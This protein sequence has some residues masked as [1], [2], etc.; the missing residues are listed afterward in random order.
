[1]PITD[2]RLWIERIAY[3]PFCICIPERH[4][5]AS[6]ARLAM[7]ELAGETLVWIPRSLHWQFYDQVASYLRPLGFDSRRFL[8]ASTITQAFDFAALGIGVALIPQ[9][10]SHFQRVGVLVKPLT[11]ELMRIETSL[12]VRRDQMHSQVKDFIAT[13]LSAISKMKLKPLIPQ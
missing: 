2:T 13:A 3:E 6:R 12:F 4:R 9:S 8:E 10:A 5:L 7:R 11:D 1:M